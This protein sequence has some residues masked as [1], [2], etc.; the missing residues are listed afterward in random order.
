MIKQTIIQLYNPIYTNYWL[1]KN[2]TNIERLEVDTTCYKLL[3]YKTLYNKV[4]TIITVA[5]NKK[6]IL[7]FFFDYLKF[8]CFFS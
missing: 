3:Y 4:I 5:L 6:K 1:C 2:T 7:S 8:H